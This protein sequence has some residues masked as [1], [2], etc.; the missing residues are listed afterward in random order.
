[1]ELRNAHSGRL[2]ATT[3]PNTWTGAARK[4]PTF[5]ICAHRRRLYRSAYPWI[6]WRPSADRHGDWMS[7]ISRWWSCGWRKGPRGCNDKIRGRKQA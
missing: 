2:P 5:A 1:M 3:A 6:C 7:P 4:W